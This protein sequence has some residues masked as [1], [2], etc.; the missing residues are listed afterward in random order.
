MQCTHPFNQRTTS[1]NP[2][3]YYL[4]LSA[5]DEVK[6]ISYAEFT[7]EIDGKVLELLGCAFYD[8]SIQA[9]KAL[10]AFTDDCTFHN[11]AGNEG[12]VTVR[13]NDFYRTLPDGRQSFAA[14][15]VNTKYYVRENETCVL[16]CMMSPCNYIF[17]RM[18]K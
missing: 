14:M 10:E 12:V 13:S 16:Y 7:R 6:P 4:V 17:Y 9:D 3:G 8:S 5:E 1:D 2:E 11:V 18:K 15:L